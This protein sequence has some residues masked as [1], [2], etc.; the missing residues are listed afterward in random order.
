VTSDRGRAGTSSASRAGDDGT[1]GASAAPVT[2][3]FVVPLPM[4]CNK[5]A[6]VPRQQINDKYLLYDYFDEHELFL[7]TNEN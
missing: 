5:T 1:S 2:P 6:G 4:A 7:E 3:S